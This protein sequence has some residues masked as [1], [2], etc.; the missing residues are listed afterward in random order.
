MRRIYRYLDN[1]AEKPVI[2]FRK[3]DSA[4]EKLF[5]EIFKKTFSEVESSTSE[6][7]TYDL[8]EKLEENFFFCQL[9]SQGGGI[10]SGNV[11]SVPDFKAW[12]NIYEKLKKTAFTEIDNLIT[13]SDTEQEIKD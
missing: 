8:L 2:I 3:Y 12:K 7:N 11:I 4:W 10:T 5:K 13:K 1:K 6:F 9:S